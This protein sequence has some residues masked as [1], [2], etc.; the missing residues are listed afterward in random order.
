MKQKSDIAKANKT[1]NKNDDLEI[2]SSRM[3][4]HEWLLYQINQESIPE[5]QTARTW[6]RYPDD[7]EI[8]CSLIGK[9]E[10]ISNTQVYIIGVLYETSFLQNEL[11]TLSSLCSRAI[12]SNN[13]EL[14]LLSISNKKQTCLF[15]GKRHKFRFKKDFIKRLSNNAKNMSISVQD[16]YLLRWWSWLESLIENSPI[17]EFLKE[18]DSVNDGL[19][20]KNKSV[21]RI[22]NKIEIMRRL[23]DR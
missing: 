23:V 15:E 19:Y 1:N 10:N 22:N 14:Q 16:L 4:A 2:I 13:P 17:Y 18:Y 6:C 9:K 21:R 11:K 20:E 12:M 5:D 7:V 8:I 3:D